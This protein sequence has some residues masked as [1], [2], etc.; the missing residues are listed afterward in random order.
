MCRVGS[1][2]IQAANQTMEAA[3][4]QRVTASR[5]ASP[6]PLFTDAAS[7]QD[8]A[9]KALHLI[10][11]RRLDYRPQGASTV[12]NVAVFSEPAYTPFRTARLQLA[13]PAYYREQTDLAPGIGDAH[14][15]TLTKDSIQWAET[16]LSTG[17]VTNASISFAASREPWI[18]CAS[19]YQRDR[20]VH[21]LKDHFAEK[22]GYTAATKIRDP[23][24]FAMW[25]G[26]DFALNL[27]KATDVTLGKFDEFC[28]GHSS[29]NPTRWPD[30][31]GQ[32]DTIV[33]VCHGPVHYE[34]NSGY[35]ASQDDWLDLHGGPRA[36][37][38]KRTSLA[39]QSEYRF[40][41]STLGDPVEPRHHI[42]VSAE[43]RALTSAL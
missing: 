28:Y 36:W 32:I 10:L 17:A 6:T 33:H 40:A 18:Y 21:R 31:S 2:A 22:Y 15:G 38:T 24:A 39:S 27:D 41:V 13:T 37:F 25:L 8:R 23:E 35:I 4:R 7:V 3:F 20:E 12:G 30:S 43:L 16:V 9:A 29:Y 26:I 5:A 34:D 14:D 19:H 11:V 42:D 1:D